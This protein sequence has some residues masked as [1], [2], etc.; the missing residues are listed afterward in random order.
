MRH[1]YAMGRTMAEGML[2]EIQDFLSA[3]K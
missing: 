3:D 1:V 2:K